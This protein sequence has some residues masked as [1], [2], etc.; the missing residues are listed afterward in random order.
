MLVPVSLAPYFFGISGLIFF[1][2]AV[3]LGMWFLWASFDAARTRSIQSARR[4]LVVT[5]IYLPVLFI[6]M[7]ANKR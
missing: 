4:L 7:V 2:G 1:I 3:V 6:L 5:V